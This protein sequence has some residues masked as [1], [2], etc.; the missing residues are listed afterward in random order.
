LDKHWDNIGNMFFLNKWSSNS[1]KTWNQKKHAVSPAKDQGC[2]EIGQIH[3]NIVDYV[4]D[5]D[6]STIYIYMYLIYS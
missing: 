5:N 6:I 1:A 2:Q 3:S 4:G